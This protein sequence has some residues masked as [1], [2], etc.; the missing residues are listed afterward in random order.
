MGCSNEIRP[1]L[2][3]GLRQASMDPTPTSTTLHTHPYLAG[4]AALV[5]RPGPRVLAEPS[6]LRMVSCGAGGG[7]TRDNDNA[8][9]ADVRPRGYAGVR[10]YGR[11]SGCAARAPAR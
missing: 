8:D 9:S 5:L 7:S 10:C 6:G 11:E 3:G 1:E 2:V 4:H